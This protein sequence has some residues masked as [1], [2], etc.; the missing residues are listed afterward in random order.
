MNNKENDTAA[1]SL[2]V[3]S[4]STKTDWS[5]CRDG[6]QI[7]RC[8]TQ[9]INPFHQDGAAISGI[10]GGEL[11]P[12]LMSATELADFTTS[13]VKSIRFYGAGC[14]G[15][16]AETLAGILKMHFRSATDVMVGSDLLAAAHAVCGTNEGIAC[17]LGT[18]ANSGLYDG[19][20]IV[21]NVS[22]LGYILGD[23]GSGAVLGKLFVNGMF[24]G[25]IP[26]EIKEEFV[27][28][29]GQNVDDIIQKVYR[30]PMAN[31]YLAS[32]APFIRE[33]LGCKEV[34]D[35]VLGNFIDFF[36]LNIE[37]YGRKDLPVGAVGSVAYYF[38]DEFVEAAHL[39]GYEVG[40]ILKAP[41]DALVCKD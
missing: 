9:G 10:I 28:T 32:F 11:L 29:T 6:Q 3:D 12:Q 38:K 26:S 4:G 15:A 7:C 19:R 39:C 34:R 40:R 41:I 5:L 21:A 37:H 33:H 16:A 35:L 2:V 30:E 18:G 22:P 8:A 24:K 13:M 36:R 25:N 23:E 14:R 31:R 1:L 27:E 20:D 17:I